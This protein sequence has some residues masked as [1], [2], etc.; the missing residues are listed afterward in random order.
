MTLIQPGLDILRLEEL[1]D[2][3]RVTKRKLYRRAQEAAS[4]AFKLGGN[5]R[6][7][8]DERNPWITED[9]CRQRG[10]HP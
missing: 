1:A 3:L 2:F 5:W 4:S 8:C 10:N 9:I 6:F 7:R